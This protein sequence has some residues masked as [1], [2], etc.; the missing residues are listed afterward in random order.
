M[1]DTPEFTVAAVAPDGVGGSIL[2][3]ALESAGIPVEVRGGRS[4]W[5]F[6]YAGGGF[7][8]VN[9]LVPR[10]LVA[11]AKEILAAHVDDVPVGRE[12]VLAEV[13]PDRTAALIMAGVLQS[14]GI[15]RPREAE[16]PD[17]A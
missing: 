5:L 3:S 6:P 4:S 13:A 14:A 1:A 11:D 15:P 10:D 17:W 8:A 16:L 9:V 7:V 2:T 12:P